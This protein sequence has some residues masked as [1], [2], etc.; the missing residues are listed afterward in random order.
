VSKQIKKEHLRE[1]FIHPPEK[2]DS[3]PFLVRLLASI[4]FSVKGRIQGGKIT[5][6]FGI[7]GGADF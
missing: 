3:R 2:E 5:K 6:H 1:I 7:R 4:K